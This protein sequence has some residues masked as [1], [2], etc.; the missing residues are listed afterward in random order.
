MSDFLS[1][2]DISIQRI[3]EMELR[4]LLARVLDIFLRSSR[5]NCSMS[6]RATGSRPPPSPK[7][8]CW[9]FVS[10]PMSSAHRIIISWPTLASGNETSRVARERSRT[11]SAT[12]PS[13]AD[14]AAAGL[15]V[16]DIDFAMCTHLAV[17]DCRLEHTAQGD[18]RWTPTFPK[19]RHLISKGELTFGRENT[20]KTPLP[21][22]GDSVLPVVEAGRAEWVRVRSWHVLDDRVRLLPTPGHTPHH[23][24]VCFGRNG[25][26]AAMPGD[27]IQ[28]RRYRHDIRTRSRRFDVDGNLAAKTRAAAF[29]DRD[30]AIRRRCAARSHFPSP[31][32]RRIKRKWTMGSAA[33]TLKCNC[34]ARKT[35]V[36]STL[37]TPTTPLAPNDASAL[38]AVKLMVAY[39]N[40][41]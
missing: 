24:A 30:I 4:L 6:N 37:A 20:P 18:G 27:L 22:F 1:V 9:Y 10:N 40:G 36:C 28:N 17:E 21:H 33:I 7:A 15:S 16:D 26:Y 8:T 2:G 39:V 34:P 29:L 11:R 23:V 38:T 3:I 31:S 12:R 13:C 41:D 32:I 25:D 5:R 35:S 19:A 14:P